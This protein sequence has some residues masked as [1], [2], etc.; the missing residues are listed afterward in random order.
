MK[1]LEKKLK[2]NII[3]VTKLNISNHSYLHFHFLVVQLVWMF[4][5][6][7][8][9]GVFP[10]FLVV[11]MTMSHQNQNLQKKFKTFPKI[12]INIFWYCYTAQHIFHWL[13]VLVMSR[14]RFRVN[15]HSIVPWMSR[16]S[17]LEAGAKSEV[18]ALF[19]N[20]SSLF[21]CSITVKA[22][23]FGQMVECSFKN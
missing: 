16:N 23:Q 1:I 22:G 10:V 20:C 7:L 3:N 12:M 21:N 13:Y 17:L 11:K 8:M 2:N 9:E 6:I 14:T 18:Q 15:R 5:H 19:K 4:V